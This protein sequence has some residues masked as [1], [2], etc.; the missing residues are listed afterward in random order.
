[1]DTAYN[2]IT[3]I[4]V[5]LP[6]AA[7]MVYGNINLV[8]YSHLPALFI[9][10]ILTIFVIKNSQELSAKALVALS[11]TYALWALANLVAWVSSSSLWIMFA[12]SILGILDIAFYALTLY[13]VYTF[14]DRKSPPNYL[15]YILGILILPVIILTPTVSNLASF[16]LRY[17][18][19]IDQSFNGYLFFPKLVIV[20]WILGFLINRF[21]LAP[22]RERGHIAL[23]GL[24]VGAFLLSLFVTGYVAD[25]FE[26]FDIEIYGLFGMAIFMGFLAYLIVRF[27]AFR[28]KLVAAQ[29]LVVALVVVVGSE[30]FFIRNP[31]NYILVSISFLF[32]LIFGYFL[33]RS[34]KKEV[35]TREYIQKLAGELSVSRDEILIANEKLK[36][37]DKQKTEF[38]SI[39][40]H[41]L[42]A[43]LTA[44]KG[45]SSML[46]EGSFGK[47]GKKSIEAVER[48]EESSERLIN[49][50]ED[51]L[52]ITR[53][54]L[55]KM[56]YEMNNFDLK[57]LLADLTAEVKP[58]F[59]KKKISLEVQLDSGDFNFFGDTGKIRQVFSNLIDNAIKYTPKGKVTISLTKSGQTIKFTIQDTGV[60]FSTSTKANMFEKFIRADNAGKTNISGTGL[61]LYVAK[62]IVEAHKGKIDAQSAGPGKGSTFTVELPTK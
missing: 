31:M 37:L 28:I 59:D 38:V 62:Q 20:L 49:V 61:G 34:V 29:A 52:N 58:S 53:I 56:K 50:I 14:V 54:E 39:A 19:A 35:E 27:K 41:Q 24:G 55:G 21:L 44:I 23:L 25:T 3:N 36:E 22:R 48:I 9:S 43:P 42:R 33:I 4:R 45:Y 10:V 2:L 7:E 46:L 15:K 12:W 51:F 16:D 26:R 8:Y 13:F 47:L 6:S 60:G 40:S 17:C 18:T 30:F 11:S 5:C 57:K 1:M 32:T